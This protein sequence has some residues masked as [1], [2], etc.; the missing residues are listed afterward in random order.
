MFTP[1]ADFDRAFPSFAAFDA[2][3]RREDGVPDGLFWIP[4]EAAPRVS[5][6]DAGDHLSIVLEVPGFAEADLK[7][8][9]VR[10]AVTISGERRSVAPEGYR[11]LRR[12]RGTLSFTRSYG[13]PVPVAADQVTATLKNGVL[14]LTLPK[15]TEVRPRS[16]PVQSAHA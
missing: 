10:D 5:W 16:I 15:H 2:F 13:L 7:V 8:E 6:E 1:W 11:T 9:V 3:R 4:N 12:E 14:T